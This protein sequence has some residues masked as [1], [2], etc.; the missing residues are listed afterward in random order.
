MFQSISKFHKKKKGK[1]IQKLFKKI[2]FYEKKINL[3]KKIIQ[4]I[5]SNKFFLCKK[6]FFL[7]F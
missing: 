1:K 3:L 5:F 6:N 2:E 7:N 4:L